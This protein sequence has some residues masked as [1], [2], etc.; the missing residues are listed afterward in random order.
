[1]LHPRNRFVPCLGQVASSSPP[2][3]HLKPSCL[4]KLPLTTKKQHLRFF[5][6]SRLTIDCRKPSVMSSPMSAWGS[7]V[8]VHPCVCPKRKLSPAVNAMNK[9]KPCLT[10]NIIESCNNNILNCAKVE[11]YGRLGCWQ[12]PVQCCSRAREG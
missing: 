11:L 7:L 10:A 1:M 5:T 8:T 12:Q 9:R 2:P 6:T 4:K 3:S